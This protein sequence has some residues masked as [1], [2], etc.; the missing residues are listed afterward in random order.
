M[1]FKNGPKAWHGFAPFHGQRR[2]IQ[3]NW[4]TR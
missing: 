4:V 2:V 1:I 3:V